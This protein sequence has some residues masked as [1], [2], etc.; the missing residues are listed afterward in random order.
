MDFFDD[1]LEDGFAR[2]KVRRHQTTEKGHGRQATRWY[3]VCPVPDNLPDR[4]R[5]RGSTSPGPLKVFR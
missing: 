2:T 4:T 3:Y 5:W 1:H